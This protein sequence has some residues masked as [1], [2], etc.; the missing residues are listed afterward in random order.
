GAGAPLHLPGKLPASIGLPS[1][2]HRPSIGRPGP[3]MRSSHSI[4]LAWATA[5][6]IAF[7]GK[8]IVAKL[9]Y[10]HGVDAFTVVGLRMALS[11]PLFLLMV[12]WAGRDRP[13]GA[14]SPL[15]RAD[16]WRVLALG[17]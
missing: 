6:A 7:S 8:A 10:R 2:F 12:W 14:S 9:M 5:G 13:G 17:F 4:G 11:L 3:S 15:S 16:A 1:A